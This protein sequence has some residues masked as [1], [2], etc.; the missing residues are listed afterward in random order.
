MKWLNPNKEYVIKTRFALFPKRIG[1]Y[2][3]WLQRYYINYDAVQRL[4]NVEYV[5][6]LY[7]Y[8]WDVEQ[9]VKLKQMTELVIDEDVH[10][11]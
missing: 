10:E 9:Q 1:D 7:I 6:H 4:S 5:K 2:T 8:K 3:I 11:F